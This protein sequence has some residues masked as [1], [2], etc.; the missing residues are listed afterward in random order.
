MYRVDSFYFSSFQIT[1]LK[2]LTWLLKI[3]LKTANSLQVLF[4]LLI[5]PFSHFLSCFD[6]LSVSVPGNLD[7]TFPNHTSPQIYFQI[8]GLVKL[9]QS[10]K[11]SFEPA[12]KYLLQNSSGPMTFKTYLFSH[13]P[14]VSKP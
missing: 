13:V 7:E 3:L 6:S 9:S 12:F 2:S 10:S 5:L 11:F 1:T 14:Q 8:L 4:E